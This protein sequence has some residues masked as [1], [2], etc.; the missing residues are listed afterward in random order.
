[1]HVPDHVRAD[2][3][4]RANVV[5]VGTG[6]KRRGG[7]E[8]GEEAVIVFVTE[9][10]PEAQLADEDV[11][12][13]TVR[14][15]DEDVPTDVVQAGEV[16]A[17]AAVQQTT[18]DRT[19]RYRPAPAS[20]SIGHPDIS[21]GTLGSPPLTTADGALV[22]VTNTHVAAPPPDA[23]E[24]DACLQPG[25][26]DGGDADDRIGTL[27]GFAPISRTEA[28]RTD[29]ALV[30][31]EPADVRDNE[32]LEIGPL[33]GFET[34]TFDAEYEKSGRT[35]GHTRGNLIATDVEIEVRGYY[36]DEPVSF[37]GVDAFTPMSSGGDSGSL[38]GRRVD[39]AF[40]ATHLLF[41]G[42]PFVTFGVPWDEVTAAHGDLAV[43]NPAPPDDGGGSGGL[44]SLLLALLRWLFGLFGGRS[45]R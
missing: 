6:P 28:N 44:F 42:S 4:S 39:G 37:A 18:P 41:A 33:A 1:M 35:T 30:A 3:L 32:I 25:T 11:C 40:Y 23:A 34:A 22:F 31:V 8:T 9:K 21:A 12:P 29:S 45:R 13:K 5:G 26:Y 14:I 16:W 15:D 19:A 2:L 17:Q 24:G 36:P 27:L 10:L 38:I 7:R 43:A 20:V